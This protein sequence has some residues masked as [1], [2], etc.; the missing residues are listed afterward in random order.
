[1]ELRNT[2]LTLLL[3]ATVGLAMA[4]PEV[5]PKAAERYWPQ[6]RGPLHTG[7][8]PRGN[9]PL[10]WG[11]EKN[12]RW[13]VE[14]PGRGQSTP[15]VWNDLVFV[16]TAVPVGEPPATGALEIRP[17]PSPE[18]A[19]T[20]QAA[21]APQAGPPRGSR[22]GGGPPVAVKAGILDFVVQAH[23]RSDGK[24]RWRKVVKT[25]QPHEGT[26]KDGGYACGSALTDGERIYAFFGSR[27][28][29]ALDL[30]GNLIWEKQLGM[31]QTRLSFGEGASPVLHGDT[32]VV[33]WD[34]EGR[35]FLVAL[36]RK[37]GKE[38][39]RTERE[40][41]TSWATPIVVMSGGKPQ[42]IVNATNR[43][44]GYDLATGK[45][46]W[47][48]GGMTQNVIPSPVSADGML[49]VTSG[50]RGTALFAVR[51]ADAQGDITGKPAVVWSYDKDTPYVP[52]PLLY[53]DGLYFL[54][55]NTAILTRIDVTTGKPSYTQRLE[56]LSNVYASPVAVA[57]RV[58]VVGREGATTVLEAGPVVKVLATN[59]LGDGFDASPALVDDEIYLR[60]QKYLYR[61]SKD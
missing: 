26:H 6:W 11:E 41:P 22:Q 48:A 10:E 35:D 55:S 14:V 18:A 3:A 42:V 32:L 52:S 47:E 27:G 43:V 40:E 12:V 4:T 13:K 57:G 46:L 5:A 61:I 56:G 23:N 54:K 37:T 44:R 45:V 17:T 51:L 2:P 20:P 1:M 28:L 24:V 34:H 59:T 50:F 49:Y 16:T 58:Y 36:D 39:W 60:G 31:M 19:A 29:Y 53:K 15:V 25:L 33:N 8:A 7:E 21:D 38:L 30:K 9:P